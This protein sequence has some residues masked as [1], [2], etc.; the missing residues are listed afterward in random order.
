M[1]SQ[2]DSSQRLIKKLGQFI[3]ASTKLFQEINIYIQSHTLRE[4]YITQ[5]NQFKFLIKA[6]I[7]RVA[8]VAWIARVAWVA[9][10]RVAGVARIAGRGARGR[11]RR[12]AGAR[13]RA[14]AGRVHRRRA[15]AWRR[16][17]VEA[18]GG[19]VDGRLANVAEADGGA[20]AGAVAAPRG[21]GCCA[22]QSWK[23]SAVKYLLSC[24][25]YII[26]SSHIKLH[27]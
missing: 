21:R 18:D 14:L 20:V 19:G 17:A 23:F 15:G 3:S 13:R 22:D 26:S 4:I 1:V 11:A 27:L 12:R 8:R 10:A 5:Q 9:R 24:C 7:A 6:R 25:Y 16:G 2:F